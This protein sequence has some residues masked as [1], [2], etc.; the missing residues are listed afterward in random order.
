MQRVLQKVDKT[1]RHLS[2]FEFPQ[3]I[4]YSLQVQIHMRGDST[5]LNVQINSMSGGT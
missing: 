5:F 1:S 3:D 2:C 4:L